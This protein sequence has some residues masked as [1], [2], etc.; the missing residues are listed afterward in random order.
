[1]PSIAGIIK[2]SLSSTL[3]SYFFAGGVAHA[4]CKVTSIE[5]VYYINTF[6]YIYC[7]VTMQNINN[8]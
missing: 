6:V 3:H 4:T 8:I 1:M 7:G 5:T 2:C